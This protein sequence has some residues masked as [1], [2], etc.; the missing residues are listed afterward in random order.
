M[1]VP[2][3][4]DKVII[5]GTTASELLLKE[6][7]KET[8]RVGGHPRVH[9]QFQDQDFLFFKIA[10]DFQIDYTDPFLLHEM[11]KADALIAILPNLNPH[12][13][14]SIDAE[15]KQ[16]RALAQQPIMETLF[17]RWEE[18]SIR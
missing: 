6:I 8:L 13:L 12:A 17:K 15:K 9:I 5:S 7:Y 14:T 1:Q 11:E 18:G 10:E 4:Q 2:H 16:K 3:K